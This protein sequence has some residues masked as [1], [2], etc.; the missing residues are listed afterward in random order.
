MLVMVL[1]LLVMVAQGFGFYVGKS[2]APVS[3]MHTYKLARAKTTEHAPEQNPQC[4]KQPCPLERSEVPPPILRGFMPLSA[5]TPQNGQSVF[6]LPPT[7]L[8]L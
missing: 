8:P 2:D 1:M 4:R 7:L 6:L 3:F 5:R